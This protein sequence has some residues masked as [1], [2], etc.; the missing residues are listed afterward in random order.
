MAIW[1]MLSSQNMSSA[2]GWN[3]VEAS[4]SIGLSYSTSNYD[5][6][7]TPRNIPVTFANA[8]NQQGIVLALHESSL[9][10]ARTLTIKLQEN[11]ASVW[12]DR[13][14]NTWSSDSAPF[15]KSQGVDLIYYFVLTSY[16]VTTAAGTWRYQISTDA[17]GSQLSIWRTTTASDWFYAVVLDAATGAPTSGDSVIF[18]QS[19]T[20]TFDQSFIFGNAGANIAAVICQNAVF[21]WANPPAAAYT[22][23]LNG[24]FL[25]GSTGSFKIGSSASPIDSSVKATID[26][27]GMTNGQPILLT[28]WQSTRV[29]CTNAIEIYGS[30]DNYLVANVASQA[31]ASQADIVTV[32][33]MSATWSIGDTVY[34]YGKQKP[35]AVDITSYTISNIVGTTVTLSA[36]LDYAVSKGGRIINYTRRNNLGVWLTGTS[37]PL[38]SQTISTSGSATCYIGYMQLAGVYLS[39]VFAV[40]SVCSSTTTASLVRSIIF[41]IDTSLG[42]SPIRVVENRA[43]GLTIQNFHIVATLS[44]FQGSDWFDLG[45]AATP[46]KGLTISNFT[47]KNFYISS[48]GS[49]MNLVANGATLSDIVIAHTQDVAATQGSILFSLIGAAYSVSNCDFLTGSQGLQLSACHNSTFTNVNIQDCGYASLK[50]NSGIGNTFINCSFGDVV[51]AG[52]TEFYVSSDTLN[53]SI[54]KNCKVGTGGVANIA[55]SLNGTSLKFHTYDE[56]ANDHRAFWTYGNTISAGDGLSDT[57]RHTTGTGKFDLRF[58]PL[59]STDALEWE[60]TI[61]T[62]DISTKTMTVA[63]WVKINSATYYAGTHQNPKLTI[64]YDDGTTSSTTATDSTSW[65]LLA[66]NF[67]P[68]TAFGEITVTVDGYTDATGTDAYFYVDDFAVLYP[69]GYK[70]DMGGLDLWANALPVVPPIATVL[71]ALDVWSASSA[72]DYGSST[73]GEKLAKKVLTTSRFLGLR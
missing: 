2:T 68:T 49:P 5:A 4:N 33:D 61:P 9:S 55:N 69:A 36:N 21:Q 54:F 31:A 16:A 70:L 22:L 35:N 23:T 18:I 3:R 43:I 6:L 11:V 46:L 30:E 1:A 29:N 72:V 47:G 53:T 34:L 40:C 52:V 63:C 15:L 73:M 13:T 58:E 45:A 26:T 48:D 57:T 42:C 32:E 12:T 19:T 67:T 37:E 66:V 17:P 51:T 64:N 27:T 59:S 14:T 44:G 71:S 10:A 8:G 65:Q 50:L 28:T 7:L 25:W 24:S 56:I 38:T 62:G 60:F 39:E 41:Y 20:L